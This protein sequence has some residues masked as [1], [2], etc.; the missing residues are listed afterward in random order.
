MRDDLSRAFDELDEGELGTLLLALWMV[1]AFG[2]PCREESLRSGTPIVHNFSAA[3]YGA[4]QQNWGI[5]QDAN[6]LMYF[7]NNHGVLIFDGLRWEIVPLAN[8]SVTRGLVATPD[9]R[10]YAGGTNEFG[11]LEAD[12]KGQ[13]VYH[14]ISQRLP[15]E[16]R[17]FSNVSSITPTSHGIYF[18]ANRMFRYYQD[19]LTMIPKDF[20]GE[21]VVVNDTLFCFEPGAGV[22]A[23]DGKVPTLLHHSLELA[24]MESLVMLP[25]P[26]AQIL[27]ITWD[28]RFTI[29]Q[30]VE[31]L[32][33]QDSPISQDLTLGTP[34]EVP[35]TAFL[36][37]N[38]IY[39]GTALSDGRLALAT[40]HGGI[41][42]TDRW[43]NIHQIIGL[44]EGLREN[45]MH[46]LFEDREHNIWSTLN[47]GISMIEATA[48]SRFSRS[49][50]LEESV[51]CHTSFK[52]TIYTGT[53]NGLYQ[54]QG[55]R[56]RLIHQARNGVWD[57]LEF[58]NR[59]LGLDR[60]LLEIGQGSAVE[61]ASISRA[62]LGTIYCL[63]TSPKFPQHIFIG[64]RQGLFAVRFEE[65]EQSEPLEVVDVVNVGNLPHRVRRIQADKQGHL[66]VGSSYAGVSYLHFNSQDPTDVSV[67]RYGAESGLPQ[68][69]RVLPDML[70]G[71]IIMDTRQGPY[72]LMD[73][74]SAAQFEPHPWLELTNGLK[75]RFFETDTQGNIWGLTEKGIGVF[76]KEGDSYSWKAY[77]IRGLNISGIF[78][79][80]DT[81]W[82]ETDQGIL[83]FDNPEC[84][85]K[86]KAFE[87]R[88]AGVRV[89]DRNV[90]FGGHGDPMQQNVSIARKTW[91]EGGSVVF[92]YAALFYEQTAAN[93]FQYFLDGYDTRWSDWSSRHQTVYTGL[94]GGHY[95]FKVRS[96]NLY[97]QEGS[98]T[99]FLFFL[100]KPWYKR[101][102]ALFCFSL[103]AAAVLG[104]GGWVYVAHLKRKHERQRQQER[105]AQ[106]AHKFEALGRLAGGIAHDF[107]GILATIY[108]F[109][110][111]IK[112]ELGHRPEV[113]VP[114][115]EIE[116]AQ[117]RGIGLVNQILTFARRDTPK[118]K[119]LNLYDELISALDL[120][121]VSVPPKVAVVRNL[122][123]H[124]GYVSTHPS[125]F[126][127]V[128]F[129]LCHNALQALGD[130]GGDIEVGLIRE[131]AD[132]IKLWVR[133]T[134]TGM[135]EHTRA[136]LFEPF[137][138]TKGLK[139]NGLG[140]AVVHGI[141][142][143]MGG[144]IRV[145][146]LPREGSTFVLT[147]RTVDPPKE[148]EP[149]G[150]KT[151]PG[152]GQRILWI[153]E[154]A[155]QLHQGVVLLRHW[156][157]QAVG[158][159]KDE[160]P[161]HEIKRDPRKTQL[162]ILG[163]EDREQSIHL[164]H[165]IAA[166]SPELPV[167][168]C[169]KSKAVEPLSDPQPFTAILSREAMHEALR[170]VLNQVL[171]LGDGGS[172]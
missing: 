96:R 57:L 145:H 64:G 81:L 163:I 74:G 159:L 47:N 80:Q 113:A 133:D 10:I 136:H 14:S 131:K 106:E 103:L 23:I 70:D 156:G 124:A 35:A 94:S 123:Q 122:D 88:L 167:V 95:T 120:F 19:Q 83:Q 5:T 40:L 160:C 102:L 48:Y 25:L 29:L 59:L 15:P 21:P 44:E 132:K 127:Q 108:G 43:G 18:R 30:S 104:L 98:T 149:P 91:D 118:L 71:Q 157:Y 77:P 50:G 17:L 166:L 78:L 4:S 169:H 7:G 105:Q 146:T 75:P 110:S 143:G 144:K 171:Q 172:P 168:W 13:L 155:Q 20:S 100:P 37:K 16:Q 27:I 38:E 99:Q 63:G 54:Y 119:P 55:G 8:N 147:F 67:F 107:K 76:R 158:V 165:E 170:D 129:N 12:A 52:D 46:R 68:I 109:S 66:W 36:A 126:H 72:L 42:I 90:V 137:F 111:L 32:I 154:G 134:G 84:L 114:L 1:W 121:Q 101:S 28:G 45:R 117:E 9:G 34:K 86:E 152:L 142:K 87:T 150:R 148:I 26:D 11:Y 153:D 61:V 139:G 31:R 92:D 22:V 39:H 112:G 62:N 125:Q 162:V 141:V 41:V 33:E 51:I 53:H 161:L 82:L 97:D 79:I 140:L 89:N 116:L 24:E 93:Q 138:T 60:T 56:F 69:N 73:H 6:G 128:V 135:D 85:G 65:T 3:E 130:Q 115:E 164:F 2:D 151:K 58:Q 49:S